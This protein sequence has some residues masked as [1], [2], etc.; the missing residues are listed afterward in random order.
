MTVWIAISWQFEGVSWLE[1]GSWD[2]AGGWMRQVDSGEV[3]QVEEAG[4]HV[5]FSDLDLSSLS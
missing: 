2:W 4:K 5:P 1:A 3:G